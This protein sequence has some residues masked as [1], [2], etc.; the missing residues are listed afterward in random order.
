M[1]AEAVRDNAW[2]GLAAGVRVPPRT[3]L[4]F[5]IEPDR[6]IPAAQCGVWATTNRAAAPAA[7]TAFLDGVPTPWTFEYKV[8]YE[9]EVSAGECIEAFTLFYGAGSLVPLINLADDPARIVL[10]LDPAVRPLRK[11][12]YEWIDT[13]SGAELG[14]GTSAVSITIPAKGYRILGSRPRVKV[15]VVRAAL[16][17]AGKMVSRRKADGFDVAYLADRLSRARAAARTGRYAK[18]T[19][20]IG[21][22]RGTP[23]IR[24]LECRQRA[25]GE[26]VCVEVDVVEP[27]GVTPFR[28]GAALARVIPLPG[29]FKRLTE[30]SPGRYTGAIPAADMTAFDYDAGRY[31]PYTGP[32]RVVINVRRRR[33]LAQTTVRLR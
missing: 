5:S 3:P 29:V 17:E 16:Q 4:R 12:D 1:E 30:R 22:L 2:T 20:Y 14:D 18:A 8:T 32:A 33:R 7:Q 6:T 23:L 21:Q 15:A 10:D 19:G 24:V 13:V 25:P 27:D 31:C 11:V 28:N 26:S 9:V